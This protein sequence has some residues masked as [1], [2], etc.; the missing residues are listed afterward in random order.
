MCSQLAHFANN[1][2]TINPVDDIAIIDSG[3]TS[4]FLG[5]NA[6]VVSK[7]FKAIP[8]RA[9][10]PTGAIMESTCTALL[11]QSDLPIAAR[12]AHLFPDLAY[13]SLLSVGQFCDSGY[14]VY[15]NATKVEVRKGD[16]VAITG[17]RDLQ[18]G[19]YLTNKGHFTSQL[20]PVANPLPPTP[21]I[22]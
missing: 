8:L 7:D 19:L 3:C 22:S 11:P 16:H 10:T 21:P 5:L 9:G 4:H 15:F 13:R 20:P 12:K 17:N 6:P 2:S 1:T 14:E 18:T